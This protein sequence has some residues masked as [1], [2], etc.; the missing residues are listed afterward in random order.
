MIKIAQKVI[1]YASVIYLIMVC[2]F[3]VYYY[4]NAL[5]FNNKIMLYLKQLNYKKLYLCN[6]SKPPKFH[7]IFALCLYHFIFVLIIIIYISIKY[8]FYINSSF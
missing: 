7:V 6:I 8:I 2:I 4:F 5:F 3:F 1:L